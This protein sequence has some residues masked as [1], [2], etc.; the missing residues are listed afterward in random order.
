VPYVTLLLALVAGCVLCAT[1][2]A[3]TI[4][5]ITYFTNQCTPVSAPAAVDFECIIGSTRQKASGVWMFCNCTADGSLILRWG[6]NAV[7]GV[8]T[9]SGNVSTNTCNTAAGFMYASTLGTCGNSLPYDE[10]MAHALEAYTAITQ[11]G[12]AATKTLTVNAISGAGLFHALAL[13]MFGYVS[14]G[15][16]VHW[17][18]K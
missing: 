8:Y 11:Q 17:I 3:D 18:K 5:R 2:P 16:Y 14:I 10:Y 15:I 9:G 7:T 6:F 12:G 13:Y 1:V 4:L